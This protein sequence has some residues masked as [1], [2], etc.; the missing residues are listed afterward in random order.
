[1][2]NRNH[3]FKNPKTEARKALKKKILLT[4]AFFLIAALSI[5]A[6]ASQMKQDSLA[7]LGRQLRQMNPWWALAAVISMLCFILTEGFSI[8]AACSALGFRPG[9]NRCCQYAA[10]DIYFSAITPSATGGQPASVL[11]MHQD[12]ISVAQGTAALLI[13]LTMCAFATFGIG[14]VCFVFQYPIFSRFSFLSRLLIGVGFLMQLVTALFLYLMVWHET[15]LHR[16]CS[17]LVRFGAKLHL[18]RNVEDK[19]DILADKMAEYRRAVGMITDRRHYLFHNLVFNFLQ[20]VSQLAVTMFVFLA[21][22][23]ES[24]TGFEIW[25]MQ[26][27]VVMGSNYVPIPGGMGVADLLLLDGFGSVMEPYVAAQ[28]ELISRS[29]SFYLCILLCG[30]I[31]ILRMIIRKFRKFNQKEREA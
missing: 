19:L 2:S 28:L 3:P 31:L 9:F 11:L 30:G 7:D 21:M 1:M 18:I 10:G 15:L 4:A 16:I 5:L 17:A 20:R 6:V 23:L 12:G 24:A 8:R 22:G 27:Y 14:V 13:N 29:L 25:A 26:G